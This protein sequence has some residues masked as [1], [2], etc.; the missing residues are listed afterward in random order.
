MKTVLVLGAN[1]GM[2]KALI[3]KLAGPDNR[4]ILASRNTA[5]LRKTAADAA[6]RNQGPEPLV[7][8]FDALR[9]DTHDRF[10]QEV[11]RKVKAVDEVYLF[12]GILHPQEE[13]QKDFS[14]VQDML[15]ANFTGA[16]SVLERLVPHLERRK[17]GLIVGVSSVAGDRGRQSNYYYGSAKAGFSAYLQGLRNRLYKSR[18]RVLTVKPGF[19]D[20]PMTRHLKK[21]LLFASAET[22]AAGIIRAVKQGRDVVYLPGYWRWIMLIVRSIPESMFKRL[23]M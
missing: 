22:I 4:L 8:G 10:V 21:G 23:S 13:A 6:V 17:Q 12:F 14:L 11:M 2:A 3:R 7:M 19:V 9:P 5:E 15:A 20:T 1:S 16:V 18:V